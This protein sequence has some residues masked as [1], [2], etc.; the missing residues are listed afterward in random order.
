MSIKYLGIF[1]T[2]VQK[3]MWKSQSW[4]P[5]LKV[6]P[7]NQIAFTLIDLILQHIQQ[8]FHKLIKSLL[9]RG[10]CQTDDALLGGVSHDKWVLMI[11]PAEATASHRLTN[12]LWQPSEPDT[13]NVVTYAPCHRPATHLLIGAHLINGTNL[14]THLTLLA[15]Q[16]SLGNKQNHVLETNMIS[17]IN[18]RKKTSKN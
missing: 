16:V 13:D 18:S 4:D 14:P 12:L 11:N 3:Y 9:F 5:L 7:T 1:L 10:R 2:Y 8:V 17:L 6:G 15:L